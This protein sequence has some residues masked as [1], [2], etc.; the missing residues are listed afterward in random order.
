[1][2]QNKPHAP[3]WDLPPPRHTHSYK[4][5]HTHRSRV[6]LTVSRKVF[7]YRE[8]SFGPFALPSFPLP[9]F[10]LC[11]FWLYKFLIHPSIHS[12]FFLS[13]LALFPVYCSK[14]FLF[15]PLFIHHN[16]VS[17]T[18]TL[19]HF[20]HPLIYPT[21]LFSLSPQASTDHWAP[22]PSLSP[23]FLISYLPKNEK[24]L[25]VLPKTPSPYYP[26]THRHTL[27]TVGLWH[28][29]SSS[30]STKV[31]KTPRC[32][33]PLISISKKSTT[34]LPPSSMRPLLPRT[35]INTPNTP[36]HI[37]TDQSDFLYC[38]EWYSRENML[39]VLNLTYQVP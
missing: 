24:P 34:S 7:N 18:H 23:F 17:V 3:H 13:F 16:E 31:S 33:P 37:R 26:H 20:L 19:S 21:I 29:P 35:H 15:L 6:N 10:N 11:K 9:L 8:W 27:V 32:V 25:P 39:T 5:T 30:P 4:H 22:L 12:S 36:R 14:H 38:D 1:M 2:L 28:P